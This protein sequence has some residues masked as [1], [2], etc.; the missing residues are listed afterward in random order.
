M[1]ELKPLSRAGIPDALEKATRYR[2]LNEPPQAESI[3]LDVLHVDPE[4]QEALV[5]LLLALTDQFQSGVSA[6]VQQAWEIV[7]KLGDSYAR[8][9]YSGIICERRARAHFRHAVPGSGAR[10][11]DWLRQAMDYY[12]RAES[13]RP[14]GNDDAILRWNTCARLI[15]KTSELRPLV[16]ERIDHM[17]E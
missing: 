12:E 1:F 4:N 15:M 5:T 14:P 17:L 11:Y 9:Y 7:P 8:E 13:T 16:E 2:L 3:C 10:A 6:E